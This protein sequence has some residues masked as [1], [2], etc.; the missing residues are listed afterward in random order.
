[1]N[2]LFQFLWVVIWVSGMVIAK[3]FWS[4]LFAFMTGGLWSLYLVIEK[5]IQTFG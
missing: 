4:T 2:N 5:I 3:G 1:M